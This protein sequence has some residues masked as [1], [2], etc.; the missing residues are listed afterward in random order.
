MRAKLKPDKRI[1]ENL[2][3]IY[4]H[5]AGNLIWT[6][7]AFQELMLMFG[8]SETVNLLNETA[9]TFFVRHKDLLLENIILSLSRMTDEK[10]SGFGKNRQ[11]NLTL[12]HL[13]DLPD[14]RCQQL[15]TELHE[16]WTKIGD[17]AKQLRTYRHKHLAHS[18]LR[19]HLSFSTKLGVDLS[20]G[21]IKKLLEQINDFLKTFDYFFTGVEHGYDQPPAT[22]GDVSDLIFHL[23]TAVETENK[24]QDERLKAVD[25]ASAR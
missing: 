13:L 16:K 1:P 3:E 20:I 17:A 10:W 2:R 25:E 14:T 15:Q 22:Y 18:D 24:I 9:P 6:Y 12:A 23:R 19:H 11:E 5:L 7:G 8:T 4:A 21:S